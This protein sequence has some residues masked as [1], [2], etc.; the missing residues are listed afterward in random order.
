M[1]SNFR[2]LEPQH[3]N[4]TLTSGEYPISKLIHHRDFDQSD[5]KTS[6]N[7]ITLLKLTTVLRFT[8]KLLPL[9]LVADGDMSDLSV[10]PT[11]TFGVVQNGGN[12]H[13]VELKGFLMQTAACKRFNQ[14]YDYFVTPKQL[15]CSK[16]DSG[17]DCFNLNSM[18][19][20]ALTI[21]KQKRIY[22]IDVLIGWFKQQSFCFFFLNGSFFL[23]GILSWWWPK[24]RPCAAQENPFVFVN[25]HSKLP[26]IVNKTSD[27]LYCRY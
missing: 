17:G 18:T 8:R 7:D 10:L 12:R 19:G 4:V 1:H 14:Y 13:F 20:A 23:L 5:P 15:L 11:S 25:V 21:E 6:P 3:I 27:A 16:I 26:W 2:P 24:Q 9:Q 22:K